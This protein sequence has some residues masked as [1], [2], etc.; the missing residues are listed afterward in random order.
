MSNSKINVFYITAHLGGGAGKAISGL[1]KD[2]TNYDNTLLLLERPVDTKYYNACIDAG[3]NV[4]V[5]DDIQVIRHLV[6]DSDLIIFNWWCH[7]LFVKVFQALDGIDKKIIIWSHI[8][9]LHYPYLPF[10][11]INMFDGCMF[12]SPCTFENDYWSD[13]EKERIRQKSA[14]VYGIG[15][16]KPAKCPH[17]T[18]YKIPGSFK[19]GYTGT[20]SFNKASREFPIICEEIKNIIPD[21]SFEMYGRMD[22]DFEESFDSEYVHFNGYTDNL[23]DILPQMDIFCYPLNVENFATTENALLEAMAAGLPVV[24]LDNPTM[25]S[26]INHGN[27]GFIA[28]NA[29]KF[30][31]YVKELYLD[32]DLRRKLGENARKSVIDRYVGKKNCEVCE[33][34]IERVMRTES[35]QYNFSA[36]GLTTPRGFFKYFCYKDYEQV[37][38]YLKGDRS[39]TLPDIYLGEGKSSFRQFNKYFYIFEGVK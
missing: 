12:T 15:D 17:K 2:L 21:A 22:D 16:Y 20:L 24:V 31:G 8:N 18:D 5:S 13:K 29:D 25:R 34:Y 38:K 10:E 3:I 37:E 27:N 35:H 11:F 30:V 28:S 23:N 33:K 36:R 14:I 4:T 26:I 9:G 1:I 32:A 7:P 6:E 39:I 19:I